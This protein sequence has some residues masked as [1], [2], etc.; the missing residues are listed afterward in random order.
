MQDEWWPVHS[1]VLTRSPPAMYLCEGMPVKI[2]DV[3]PHRKIPTLRKCASMSG[4]IR[5]ILYNGKKSLLALNLDTTADFSNELARALRKKN[6][7]DNCCIS[8]VYGDDLCYVHP[9]DIE[10]KSAVPDPFYRRLP[11][12][13][14]MPPAT[15]PVEQVKNSCA[16]N[17]DSIANVVRED[18]QS[19]LMRFY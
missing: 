12:P 6:N 17:L 7:E 15:V 10:P 8:S 11:L 13:K 9:R 19:D 4:T 14:Q 3:L 16:R 18:L 5:Y 1:C 2:V